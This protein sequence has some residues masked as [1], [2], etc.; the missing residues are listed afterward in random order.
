MNLQTLVILIPV[1]IVLA[2]I[3]LWAAKKIF[4]EVD[5][6]QIPN[7]L[8]EYWY[9]VV[10]LGIALLVGF[11]YVLLTYPAWVGLG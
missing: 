9:I 7:L 5:P 11:V 3:V 6:E 4:D 8:G 1:L 10:I 2:V